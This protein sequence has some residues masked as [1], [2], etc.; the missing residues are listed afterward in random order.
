MDYDLWLE[1]GVADEELATS[2]NKCQAEYFQSDYESCPY[3]DGILCITCAEQGI[4]SK[5]DDDGVCD[6]CEA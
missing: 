3:C 6:V 2:C 5:L 4:E 1:R